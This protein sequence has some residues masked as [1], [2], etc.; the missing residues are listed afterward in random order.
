MLRPGLFVNVKI[1]DAR[2]VIPVAIKR[3][4]VQTYNDWHVVFVKEGDQFEV[5]PVELGKQDKEWVEV[6]QGLEAGTEYV[7]ANSYLF[8][9]ELGKS[10]ATH[11]H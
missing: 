2:A 11:D 1:E 4:A 6:T 3:S 8:K 10:T 9:A 7:S 5:R